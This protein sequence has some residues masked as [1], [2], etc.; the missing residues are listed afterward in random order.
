MRPGAQ[1]RSHFC[2]S[3][4]CVQP[5]LLQDIG[6]VSTLWEQSLSS[7]MLLGCYHGTCSSS[8]SGFSV[9]EVF[10]DGAS[11]PSSLLFIPTTPPLALSC[12]CCL[13]LLRHIRCPLLGPTA[14]RWNSWTALLSSPSVSFLALQPLKDLVFTSVV[15]PKVPRDKDKD[16]LFSIK[17]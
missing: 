12:S 6:V 15:R 11:V 2:P 3:V 10:P 9:S 5:T 14:L 8:H 13:H 7:H 17:F 4:D 16:V 1:S